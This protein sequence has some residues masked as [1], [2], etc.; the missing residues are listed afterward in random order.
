MIA[1]MELWYK[2]AEDS[3]SLFEPRVTHVIL[4][5]ARLSVA[6]AL[7]KTAD[8]MADSI[9]TKWVAKSW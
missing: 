7:L 4:I 3:W 1:L 2:L 9:L 8:S 5:V 6:G